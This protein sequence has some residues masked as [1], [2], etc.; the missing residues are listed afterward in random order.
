VKSCESNGI[1]GTTESDQLW[2][3]FSIWDLDYCNHLNINYEPDIDSRHPGFSDMDYRKRRQEIADIAFNYKHGEPIPR[4]V[5]AD[6]EINTWKLIYT[7][8]NE[9]YP[10]YACKQHRDALKQL[11]K[12]NIYS[13]EFIPQ[14]EDVSKFLKKKSGF[15]LRPVAG[16][17]TAR[18]F[19]ASLAFRVF[20][21]TQYIR[22]SSSP[23]HSPEP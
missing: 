22:H 16:L 15:Q 9:M 4:V 12:E 7:K 8:L 3:P 23:L 13:P 5:Y 6:E 1:A 17:L 21:C 18:D 19:L 20:Q 2:I 14:L 11:E 10:T